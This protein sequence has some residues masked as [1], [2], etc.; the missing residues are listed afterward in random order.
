MEAF[1]RGPLNLSATP[2]CQK[3]ARGVVHP[4]ELRGNLEDRPAA[5]S[6]IGNYVLGFPSCLGALR[7]TAAAA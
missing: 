7:M 6:R 3:A 4:G 1:I 5:M 2:D